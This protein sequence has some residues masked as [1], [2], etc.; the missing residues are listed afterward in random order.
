FLQLA[1]HAHKAIQP[2]FKQ[3]RW[4]NHSNSEIEV[5]GRRDYARD[6]MTQARP[7]QTA[8][9]HTSGWALV[10]SAKAFSQRTWRECRTRDS[11]NRPPRPDLGWCAFSCKE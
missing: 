9:G 4:F 1:D 8:R 2:Q 5:R 11:L 7:G 10:C 6:E 3:I